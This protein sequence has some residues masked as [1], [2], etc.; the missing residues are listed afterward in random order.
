MF[1][2]GEY[3]IRTGDLLP[4]S[5]QFNTFNKIEIRHIILIFRYLIKFM[6]K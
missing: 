6:L 2:G 3:R 4:A 5:P 1:T